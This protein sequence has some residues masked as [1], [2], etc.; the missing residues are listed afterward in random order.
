MKK[1]FMTVGVLVLVGMTVGVLSRAATTGVV[2]ATVTV[3]NIAMSITGGEES[4]NYGN[5]ANN[6]AS[7]TKNLY[8][9]E[10]GITA[11]N[12]GS[13]ADFDIYGADTASWTLATATSTSDIYAH[14]FCNE[15]DGACLT[16]TDFTPMTTSPQVLKNAVAVSGTVDFQLQMHTPNPSTV[17][18]EQTAATTVQASAPN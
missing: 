10:T 7:S 11:V 6:T 4:F 2:N 14:R 18:T 5:M 15:T 9:G 1:I 16:L 3:T 8:P 17:Y 12:G 13:I